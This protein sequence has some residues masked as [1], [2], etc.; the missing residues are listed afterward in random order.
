MA[1][2]VKQV[3]ITIRLRGTKTT[4]TVRGK[5]SQLF[6]GSVYGIEIH[7]RDWNIALSAIRVKTRVPKSIP[8]EVVVSHIENERLKDISCVVVIPTNDGVSS[9]AVR[10]EVD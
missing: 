6:R 2:S 9:S 5:K 4:A 1:N 10:L 8:E 3:Y 7:K